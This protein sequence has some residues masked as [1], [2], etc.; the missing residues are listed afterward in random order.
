MS[1]T[2]LEQLKFTHS[3][4]TRAL[5]TVTL[6]NVNEVP[7]G[8][9]NSI[10]WNVGHILVSNEMLL[11]ANT[12]DELKLSQD[13]INLFKGGTKPSDWNTEPPTFKVICNLLDEQVERIT[14]TY[15]GRLDEELNKSMKIANFEM[16]TVRDILGFVIFHEGLHTGLINGLKR[17]QGL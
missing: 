9:N 13:V 5:S 1:E 15:E 12:G 11:F 10:L 3:Y 17:A 16:K 14:T 2:I 6:E 8:F 4:L 7:K